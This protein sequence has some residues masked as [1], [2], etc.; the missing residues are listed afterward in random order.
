MR[1]LRYYHVSLYHADLFTRFYLVLCEPPSDHNQS[2]VIA[3]KQE[4]CHWIYPL[5]ANVYDCQ[6]QLL[7]VLRQIAMYWVIKNLYQFLVYF[8]RLVCLIFFLP[9]EKCTIWRNARIEHTYDMFT[10]LN[11]SIFFK[12]RK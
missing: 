9:V 12:A 6:I 8:M 5:C 2:T 7:N 1:E 11:A 10:E 4:K 3:T